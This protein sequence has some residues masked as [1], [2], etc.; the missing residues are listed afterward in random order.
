M[1]AVI[2]AG[3]AG[4][5]L[6]PITLFTPKSMIDVNG[7]PFLVYIIDMLKKGGVTEIVLCIGYLAEKF[8]E[9]FG[10]G[11]KFGVKIIYS[12]EKE[13]LGTAGAIKLA[14]K[15]LKDEF[16]VIN[17]DTYLP[18]NYKEVADKFKMYG[19]SGLVVLYDNGE[20]IAEPNMAIDDKGRV[21]SYYKREVLKK[22]DIE[23]EKGEMKSLDY[24][25]IDAGV[26]MFKRE[27]FDRLSENKFVSIELDIFPELI[28]QRQLASF[29]TDKRYY[30]LGTHERLAEIKK[31]L[32]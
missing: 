17:G 29:V 15:L 22:G 25:Y 21:S 5:R 20:K 23:I 19:N 1:Q 7:K 8:K 26:Q 12:V 9:Y 11:S 13:F 32:K 18:I 10:D 16:F 3:G 14:G 28:A 4:T 2:L 24:N 30:D 27:V 6:K 31:V